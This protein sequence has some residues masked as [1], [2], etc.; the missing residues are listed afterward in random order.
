MDVHSSLAFR[1]RILA[2]LTTLALA[3][4]VTACQGRGDVDDLRVMRLRTEFVPP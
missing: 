3:A 2:L 1:S 4:L